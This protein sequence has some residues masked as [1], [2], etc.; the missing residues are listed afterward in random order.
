[1]IVPN[2]DC[3]F[4]LFTGVTA[5]GL[6]FY[7]IIKDKVNTYSYYDKIKD[8]YKRLA[9]KC[10]KAIVIFTTDELRYH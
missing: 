7:D 3:L 8:F 10:P 4:Y 9:E 2:E 5:E 1:L 6:L